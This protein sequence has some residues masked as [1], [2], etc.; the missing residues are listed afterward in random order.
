MLIGIRWY[1]NV[2]VYS[3]P[4]IASTKYLNGPMLTVIIFSTGAFPFLPHEK[5]TIRRITEQIFLI[6]GL[7][8]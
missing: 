3:F 2:K 6:A 4:A 1:H 7:L 8:F 5:K